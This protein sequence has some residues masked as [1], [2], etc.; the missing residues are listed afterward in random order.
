MLTKYINA[1]LI[2]TMQFA[3]VLPVLIRVF[4]VWLCRQYSYIYDIL[5]WIFYPLL[6]LINIS[7]Y[8]NPIM[9]FVFVTLLLSLYIYIYI[10][11]SLIPRNFSVVVAKFCDLFDIFISWLTKTS[12]SHSRVSPPIQSQCI[13]C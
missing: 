2:E 11:F 7:E 5:R 4:V 1:I 9:V 8:N 10:S 3:N 13:R 12:S 6:L